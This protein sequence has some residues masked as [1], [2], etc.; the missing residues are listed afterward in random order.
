VTIDSLS[1]SVGARRRLRGYAEIGGASLILGTSGA[2]LM[3]SHAPASLLLVLRMA[4]AGLVL[5]PLFL[6]TGGVA[7]VRRSGHPW[8]LALVGCTVACEM[9]FYFAAI[10]LAGVAIGIS[11]E[12]MAP[13][14]VVIAA[15]WVLHTRRARSDTA[16]IVLAGA[17][18]ALVVV[19]T[20]TLAGSSNLV[21]G[22]VCGLAAG[23]CYAAALLQMKGLGEAIRGTTYTLSFCVCTVVLVTPLAAWQTVA[24]HYRLTGEDVAIVVVMGLVYTALCFSLFTDGLRFVPVEHAGIIGYLEPVTAPVWALV[25]VGERPP[26]STWLGGALI[27][28]AGALA[29]ALGRA[30][31]EVPA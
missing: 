3:V 17:G 13:V 6:L 21:P 4:L 9:V 15:P 29:I 25:L 18:M 19:P 30:E 12:Y 16:A 22:V 14:Y 20:L 2:L 26:L 27:I 11:L 5:G 1:P 28:A 31:T 8:R 10:R 24:G 23:G 7:E